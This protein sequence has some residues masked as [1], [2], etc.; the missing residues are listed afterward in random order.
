[1][2]NNRLFGI[3]YL[4][5]TNKSMTAAE[6]AAYFEVS[7]RTIYRDIDAL[8]ECHIPV[9]MSKGKNGGI[10]LLDN[11]KLDKT[12]LSDEEQKQIL[13]SLQGINK[14]QIDNASA[15]EKLK[16]I[17]SKQDNDWF[18]VDF[19]VWSKSDSHQKSFEQLKAAIINQQRITF[20]Y[21]S[22]FG[23]YTH[24]KAEPYKLCFKHNAW[25][26]YA[27]DIDKQAIRFFKI[28]RM[29]DITTTNE[30][31]E[32]R[33]LTALSQKIDNPK[34][35]PKPVQLR[36]LI[37]KQQAYR[38]YDEFDEAMITTNSSGDFIIDVEFPES[39]W[40]YGFILSFG[41]DATVLAPQSIKAEIISRLQ[42]NLNNYL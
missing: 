22:T 35:A 14:L 2:K 8:S 41:S 12:L 7:T 17:F 3:I 10:R 5:L 31:F 28:M 11:Y 26:L 38:V 20:S 33:A 15:Y 24:R 1:M 29:K 19:S 27:Y 23:E 40:I 30:I 9:Y 4:L 13:F 39:D 21:F 36:L 18:E 6:L 25:Y 34:Y 42:K 37:K 32:R 16:Q